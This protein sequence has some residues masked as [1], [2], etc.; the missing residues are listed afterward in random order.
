MNDTAIRRYEFYT[1]GPGMS[2]DSQYRSQTW[3][4][5]VLARS[6]QQARDL[7]QQQQVSAGPD[8]K[9]I[10]SVRHN[11][12]STARRNWAFSDTLLGR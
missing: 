6:A 4:L 5:V 8:E 12:W 10:T 9:G 1:A 2:I 3:A 11:D 7:I